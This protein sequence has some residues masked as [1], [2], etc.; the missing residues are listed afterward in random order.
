MLV[1]RNKMVD[2]NIRLHH[3]WTLGKPKSEASFA[4]SDGY[5]ALASK[6]RSEAK[7]K[8]ERNE[9]CRRWKDWPGQSCLETDA[10]M[11]NRCADELEAQH[12]G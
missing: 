11:L 10:D 4:A 5:A 2:E 7:A 3:E 8:L 12:N 9:E 6:W 1:E